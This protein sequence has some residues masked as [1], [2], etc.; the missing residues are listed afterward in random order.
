MTPS[1][2]RNRW[3]GPAAAGFAAG[4]IVGSAA[5]GAAY[6]GYAPGY[7]YGPRYDA[8]AYEPAPVYAEPTYVAPTYY[9]G[10]RRG[11]GCATQGNYGVSVDRSACNQ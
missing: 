8:Y 1:E 10:Y 9:Y 3:V 6:G 5:A 11:S 7:A 2:A 4:A